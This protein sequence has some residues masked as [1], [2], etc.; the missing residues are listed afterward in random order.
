[1]FLCQYD[2][3]IKIIKYRKFHKKRFYFSGISPKYAMA[4]KTHFTLSKIV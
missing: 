4:E 3:V 2:I 1:M